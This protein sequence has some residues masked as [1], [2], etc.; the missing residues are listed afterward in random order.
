MKVE[1]TCLQVRVLQGCDFSEKKKK[2]EEE[3]QQKKKNNKRI[4]EA[5]VGWLQ[6]NQREPVLAIMPYNN[7]V[8]CAIEKMRERLF[9]VLSLH[10]ILRKKNYN[11]SLL[12]ACNCR[13]QLLGRN[14]TFVI[15]P[16]NF[17]IRSR[18]TSNPFSDNW[19]CISKIK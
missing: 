19:P 10:H 14:L 6:K 8:V 4:I 11:D 3:R 13:K 9:L 15:L 1:G 16:D 5:F 17:S 12:C 2:E 7:A 18:D